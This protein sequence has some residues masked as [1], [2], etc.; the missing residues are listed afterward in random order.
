MQGKCWLSRQISMA[1][2]CRVDCETRRRLEPREYASLGRGVPVLGAPKVMHLTAGRSL[3]WAISTA[4]RVAS[5]PP[6]LCP[7]HKESLSIRVSF[8]FHR[9]ASGFSPVVKLLL[10]WRSDRAMSPVIGLITGL[11]TASNT[12][13]KMRTLEGCHLEHLKCCRAPC[14]FVLPCFHL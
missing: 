1:M 2:L 7:A 12:L 6:R 13:Q 8:V 14:L 5:A 3:S 11:R 10:T 4:A 9:M